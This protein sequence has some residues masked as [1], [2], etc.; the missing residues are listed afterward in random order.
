MKTEFEA[1]FEIESVDTFRSTLQQCNA[2]LLK[3]QFLQKRYTFN[4]PGDE[5]VCRYARVRDEG[6]K[7]TMTYKCF[8]GEGI[9]RQQEVELVVDDFEQACS[10]LCALGLQQKAYQENKRELWTLQGVEVTIET[11]P[12]LEPFVEIEGVDEQSVQKVSELLGFDYADALFDSIALMYER[13]YGIS[14][15][16]FNNQSPRVTFAS[17]C[18][19]KKSVAT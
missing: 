6:D 19:W 16:V 8:E 17:P 15:T 3:D 13:A 9:E 10:F 11:W 2:V 18:P 4:L 14:Q 12:W 5:G 1:M 7:I